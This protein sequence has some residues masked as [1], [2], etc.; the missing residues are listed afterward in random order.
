[1]PRLPGTDWAEGPQRRPAARGRFVGRAFGM[2]T[3]AQPGSGDPNAR[4]VQR[5]FAPEWAARG[6]I[7]RIG[8]LGN[9][10]SEPPGQKPSPKPG[11]PPRPWN[12]QEGAISDD[13]EEQRVQPVRA[14]VGSRGAPRPMPRSCRTRGEAGTGTSDRI[15]RGHAV[16]TR[17]RPRWSQIAS[18]RNQMPIGPFCERPLQHAGAAGIRCGG[19]KGR[20]GAFRPRKGGPVSANQ[21]DRGHK[22]DVWSQLVL[23]EAR[24][25]AVVAQWMK[26]KDSLNDPDDP[27]QLAKRAL[28][29]GIDAHLEAARTSLSGPARGRRAA[30]IAVGSALASVHAAEEL[31]LRRGSV[32]YVRGQLPDI[33][34]DVRRHLDAHDPRRIRFEA[35]LGTT[36]DEFPLDEAAVENIAGASTAAHA[37]YRQEY[38]QLRNFRS[39]LLISAG[40]LVMIAVLVGLWGFF[41]PRDLSLCFNP[42]EANKIVCPT[43]E[44][45]FNAQAPVPAGSD[46]DDVVAGAAARGDIFLVE[47]IGMVA[48]A[49]SG[50]TSLRRITGS[51]TPYGLAVA[52][53]VM[54]LPTG[55]LTAVLGLMLMRGGFIPGLTAL[56]NSPQILAWAVV[57]GAA[58]QLFTGLVDRQ[59][60]NVLNNVG[61]KPHSAAERPATG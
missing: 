25:L 13:Q 48:A 7:R 37:A 1:M 22:D 27:A 16:V 57:F 39:I 23:S 21:K 56:D 6:A 20:C 19:C 4:A 24:Q 26:T 44:S 49:V 52:L 14:G 38:A 29:Q 9:S 46:I 47:F 35:L 10:S 3:V 40:I 53:A 8:A 42:Q 17:R 18:H 43:N 11:A 31:L 5:A 61:G 32:G 12:R 45:R 58:Q 30:G 15:I 2:G 59:A 41:Q 60:Q 33:H 54:K 36:S 51:S 55:A 34:S 28:D 50:A